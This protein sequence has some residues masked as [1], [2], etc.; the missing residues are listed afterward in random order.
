MTCIDRT[1]GSRCPGYPIPTN[2]NTT[3]TPGPGAVVGSRIYVTLQPGGNY[4][5]TAPLGLYCWDAAAAQPCGYVVVQRFASHSDPS[6]SGPVVVG[7]KVY[8][9][10][11]GG[12]LYCV[13]PATNLRC[14]AISTGL[15]PDLGGTYDITSHGSR[16][17]V[18][19][20]DDKVACIDVSAGAPCPGWA[21]PK[22]LATGQWNVVNRFNAQGQATGVCVVASGSGVCYGDSNPASTTQ[23][24]WLSM[25][26]W[27]AFDTE[28]ETGSRT[29]VADGNAGLACWDW[30]TL[31]PCTGGDYE[32]GGRLSHDVGGTQLSWAYGAAFD[33]SCVLG[34]GDPGLVFSID[35][36]GSSPCSSLGASTRTLDLREQR[37]DGGV[38]RATWAQ[39]S[40]QD[41]TPSELTSVVL[42]VRDGGTRQVLATK[43]IT[44]G[45]LDLS[46]IDANAHPAITV[47]ATARS[48]PGDAAWA[49]AVPPR[50]RIAWHADPR[51]L[52]FETTTQATCEV[53]PVSVKAT[54][55]EMS[56]TKQLTLTT[57]GCLPP[58]PKPVAEV[59]RSTD[60]VLGCSDRRVVL[61]DV[62]IEG[63]KVRLLGV[64]A[65][66]FA[67]RKVLLAFGPT[68]KTVAQATVGADGHFTA[69]APL[70][71]RKLRN[72]NKA[73]YVAKI[74]SEASLALKL[75]RRMLVTKVGAAGNRV[76]IAG[77]VI[78]P[79]ATR[80]KDRTITLQR[81]VACKSTETVRTF[82]PA[83]SGSFSVTV[84]APAGQKAAVYRLST[85]VRRN[86][87]AKGLTT[88]FTLPRAVDFG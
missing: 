32:E 82:A 87:K 55:G 9:V 64:A 66:E 81:V 6:A 48:A 22:A 18:S 78:G 72:S 67:G 52:C 8:V 43:D 15:L 29:L 20:A 70:P 19:R 46:A 2:M 38:G 25:P 23:I 1:T 24:E 40:L 27:F 62:F 21:L 16:V 14:T 54:L 35:P 73:R 68:A 26:G 10:G 51:Q 41:A 7:G 80:S 50:I 53:A 65:R 63:K 28:A 88:T 30:V 33:G 76:T 56:A 86:T 5:Q 39:A 74:G 60:L 71:A 4:F 85:R 34:L 75:A 42:T 45:P 61:E 44:S 84:N 3:S 83:R 12:K 69:T 13:D 47:T 31:A 59:K 11:D 57:T 17:Y 36:K 37:C 77:K 49:D 58:A 79:L